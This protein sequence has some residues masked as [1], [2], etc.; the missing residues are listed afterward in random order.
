MSSQTPGYDVADFVQYVPSWQVFYC[1][2][3]GNKVLWGTPHQQWNW[4]TQLVGTYGAAYIKHQ[5]DYWAYFLSGYYSWG[6]LAQPAL[7]TTPG[8]W[9]DSTASATTITCWPEGMGISGPYAGNIYPAI[10]RDGLA[11]AFLDGHAQFVPPGDLIYDGRW[12][13]EILRAVRRPYIGQNPD[14]HPDG[15]PLD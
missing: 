8:G 3:R 7:D 12:C 13:A 4:Q 1:P 10:H 2:S 6:V 9:D 15:F 11:S 5:L 14:P